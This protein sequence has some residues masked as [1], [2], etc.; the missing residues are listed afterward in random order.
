AR[1]KAHQYGV[2]IFLTRDADGDSFGYRAPNVL[3]SF[4]R[5][6]AAENPDDAFP[7]V[8]FAEKLAIGLCRCRGE[9]RCVQAWILHYPAAPCGQQAYIDAVAVGFVDDVI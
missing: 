4:G 1:M 7:A 6:I 3:D 9:D 8:S 2:V 5:T